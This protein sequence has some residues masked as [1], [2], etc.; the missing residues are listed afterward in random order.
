MPGGVDVVYD[1]VGGEVGGQSLRSL[2][3]RGRY[4]VVGFAAGPLTQLAANRLLLK[5]A[6]ALR[7]F[8]GEARRRDPAEAGRVGQAVL[9]LYRAGRLDPLIGARFPLDRARDALDAL[10]GRRTMGKVL[11][12]PQVVTG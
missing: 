1:P 8:W 4:L 2:A 6:A 5:E 3:W 9:E 10:A 7:V 11:L 12:M